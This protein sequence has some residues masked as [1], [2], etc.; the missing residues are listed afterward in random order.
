MRL[1]SPIRLLRLELRRWARRRQGRDGDVIRLHRRRTYI[2]PTWLG[3]GFALTLLAMLMASMNYNNSMAFAL[4]FLLAGLG[5]VT[6]H[7]C[8]QNL[9]GLILRDI[10]VRPAFAGGDL[11]VEVRL[12]NP[13]R[14]ARLEL[15]LS[16]HEDHATP[17][18]LAP[19]ETA[20]VRIPVP[21]PTRGRVTVDR[22]RVGSTFPFG[23]FQCWSW[24]HPDC[25]GIVYPA[26]A[27]SFGPPPPQG[28]DTG[29]AQDDSAGEEDF[30]GLRNFRPGD[31]PRRIAWKA[32]ARSVELPVKQ[33]A[34]TEVTSH[35]LDW[36]MLEGMPV[37]IR[38]SRLC[39]WILEAEERGHAWGL[40]LPGDEIAPAIG[41][42]HR[43]RCL[44]AL[45]LFPTSLREAQVAH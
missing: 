6:M 28:V 16:F 34:G 27:P 45:A 35:W 8:H 4:T 22:V 42:G 41:S 2:L 44:R 20:V 7:W 32:A 13:S 38:L 26:P 15:R 43:H 37:E 19:E 30:A 9:T 23:L 33:F 24:L 39:R 18:D 25:E 17:V 31:S 40:R 3:V 21:A 29:G 12:T 5:I 10:H 1:Y 14:S 36:D 11:E